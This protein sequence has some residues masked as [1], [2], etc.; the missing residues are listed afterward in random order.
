MCAS[1]QAEV[2][3][4]LSHNVLCMLKRSNRDR[5]KKN[6]PKNDSNE[7]DGAQMPFRCSNH[8]KNNWSFVQLGLG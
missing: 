3:L 6:T 5:K 4:L 8:L 1:K 7:T 2:G